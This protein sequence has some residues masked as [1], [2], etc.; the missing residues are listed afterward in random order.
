MLFCRNSQSTPEYP[1][2]LTVHRKCNKQAPNVAWFG[3]M[4]GK[5]EEK[6]GEER[7][8]EGRGG[9]SALGA[10]ALRCLS[11]NPSFSVE[12]VK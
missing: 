3:G 12:Y 10:P 9:E 11:Q 8:G 1:Q 2:Y 7:G 6:R 5:A 4:E